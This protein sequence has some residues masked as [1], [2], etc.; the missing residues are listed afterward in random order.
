M[1]DGRQLWSW[2]RCYFVITYMNSNFNMAYVIFL[3]IAWEVM[4]ASNFSAGRGGWV[5][6]VPVVLFPPLP[7]CTA[8]CP[9][10]QA[11]PGI[12]ISIIDMKFLKFRARE[13][14]VW[15]LKMFFFRFYITLLF[16]SL[17]PTFDIK[18]TISCLDFFPRNDSKWL[19]LCNPKGKWA[20]QDRKCM[21]D[22]PPSLPTPWPEE[23]PIRA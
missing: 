23:A 21:L 2:S 11:S 17:Y 9:C 7:M 8:P 12:L 19:G 3:V 13:L 22:A 20:G 6:N 5:K 10:S 4:P 1:R 15:D 16:N 14:R 18:I